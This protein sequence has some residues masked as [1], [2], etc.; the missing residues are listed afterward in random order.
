[1]A[2]LRYPETLDGSGTDYIKFTFYEYA[3]ALQGGAQNTYASYNSST[4]GLTASKIAAT[5]GA[6][7]GIAITMPNDIGSNFTGDWG[8]FNMTG[9]GRAAMGSVAGAIKTGTDIAKGKTGISSLLSGFGSTLTSTAGA[10]AGGLVE[11]SLRAI[12][13][14]INQVPGLGG[15]FSANT[16]LGLTSGY[17]LN[18]NTELLYGGTQLRKHGYRFKLI[19]QSQ[20]EARTIFNI[21]NLFKQV[22]APKGQDQEFLKL[23]NRNFI[24]IPDVCQ[25]SF[26][27]AGNSSIDHP[28]LPKYKVSAITSV[29]A[30]YITEG[31]YMTFTNGEPIGVNLTIELTELK[32]VFSNEIG[33]GNDQYR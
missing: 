8:S 14:G 33:S 18:P 9:L 3:A 28:Y 12:S 21:V 17:I 31:Q 19:A 29:A 16:I 20:N 13:D 7:E 6:A 2:T 32:L 23:K 11:D 26:H 4:T 22:T 5:A 10:A 30:D 15:N 24:G 25:V 1:M 27:L